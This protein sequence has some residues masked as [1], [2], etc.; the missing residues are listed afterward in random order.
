MSYVILSQ[1]FLYRVTPKELT[2]GRLTDGAETI[3]T[4]IDPSSAG[5][6]IGSLQTIML[7]PESLSCQQDAR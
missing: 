2:R 3:G 7:L 4:F 6:I 1:C 5:A